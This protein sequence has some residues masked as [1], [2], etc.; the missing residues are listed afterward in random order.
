VN[1]CQEIHH[2]ARPQSAAKQAGAPWLRDE[3]TFEKLVAALL[4][5]LADV[6]VVRPFGLRP[7]EVCA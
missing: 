1:P 4:A 7:G 6:L 5:V 2:R 3:K